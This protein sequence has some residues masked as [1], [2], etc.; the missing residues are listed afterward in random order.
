VRAALRM[1]LGNKSVRPGD[2]R[3]SISEA[4]RISDREMTT[5]PGVAGP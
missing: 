2:N 3:V 1:E 5:D 4:V